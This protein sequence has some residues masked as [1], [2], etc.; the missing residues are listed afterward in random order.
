MSGFFPQE[1]VTE[2]KAPVMVMEGGDITFSVSSRLQG[3]AGE[4]GEAGPSGE[5]GIPV[6]ISNP[7][8]CVHKNSTPPVCI[9][10]NL[11]SLHVCRGTLL[12]SPC[13]HRDLPFPYVY[14]EI[15]PCLCMLGFCAS[16]FHVYECTLALSPHICRMSYPA[17][18]FSFLAGRCWCSR[19]AW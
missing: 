5:P 11:P 12:L 3:R 7:S 10:G 8:L 19:G 2:G 17:L 18:T 4:L 6:S 15:L 9:H 13:V 1:G 16:P 14:M